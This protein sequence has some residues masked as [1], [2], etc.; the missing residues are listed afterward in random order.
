VTRQAV[1]ID[2]FHTNSLVDDSPI[3]LWSLF[4]G[5]EAFFDD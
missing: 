3:S 2:D 1:D 5:A 4:D